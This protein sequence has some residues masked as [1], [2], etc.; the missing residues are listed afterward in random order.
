MVYLILIQALHCIQEYYSYFWGKLFRPCFS[1]GINQ[2]FLHSIHTLALFYAH[3]G[4]SLISIIQIDLSKLKLFT[5]V[6][7]G[8]TT[9]EPIMELNVSNRIKVKGEN[10]CHRNGIPA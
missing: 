9:V 3:T 10:R 8:N 1:V 2:L 4:S 5:R 6:R 7:I